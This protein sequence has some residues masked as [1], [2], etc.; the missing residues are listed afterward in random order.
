GN[1]RQKRLRLFSER[2]GRFFHREGSDGASRKKSHRHPGG[3]DLDFE[4]NPHPSHEEN[5]RLFGQ[6][7]RAVPPWDLRGHHRKEGGGT[8]PD[9][10]PSRTSGAEGSRTKRPATS[11]LRSREQCAERVPRFG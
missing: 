11:F 5:S 2:A 7:Y 1:D 9:L 8:G 4:G 10:P 6:R 3:T